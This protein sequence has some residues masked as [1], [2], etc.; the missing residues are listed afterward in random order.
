MEGMQL[1]STWRAPPSFARADPHRSAPTLHS[2]VR[3]RGS[4]D[5]LRPWRPG[6]MR[7][8]R[9]DLAASAS[10]AQ[11]RTDVPARAPV[12]WRPT[13]PSQGRAVRMHEP[14]LFHRPAPAPPAPTAN[15]DSEREIQL[16]ALLA[17][18]HVT[19]SEERHKAT[20]AEH[21]AREAL[22]ALRN[23]H[24]AE[25]RNLRDEMAAVVRDREALQRRTESLERKTLETRT[26]RVED[27][28]RR[29]LR[30]MQYAGLTH[31][32]TQWLAVYEEKQFIQGLARRAQAALFNVAPTMR[33][34]FSRWR[35]AL[36]S[37]RAKTAHRCE[38]DLTNTV[39][40]LEAEIAEITATSA[41]KQAAARDAIS[42]LE[43]RVDE[44]TAEVAEKEAALGAQEQA[45]RAKR[46]EL[47]SM[48]ASRRFAHA[49]LARGWQTWLSMWRSVAEGKAKVRMMQQVRM[50]FAKPELADPF[51]I[52]KDFWEERVK[53]LTSKAHRYLPPSSQPL[54]LPNIGGCCA[55]MPPH[56]RTLPPRAPPVHRRR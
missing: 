9:H 39:A 40:Q 30:R 3:G 20:M 51:I 48:Q 32:W 18:A 47:L 17:A 12:A 50:R 5:P 41:R 11:L 52:W 10:A 38:L 7:K 15:Q 44:L 8:Q 24:A 54:P 42:S 14:S 31:G 45:E 2:Y 28:Y 27:Y 43:R 35:F 16:S 37:K 6:A 34:G 29:A 22:N 1:R 49:G 26:G 55:C 19:I 4:D 25:V 33:A 23:E 13:G 46:V 53:G 21:D 36:E 56:P